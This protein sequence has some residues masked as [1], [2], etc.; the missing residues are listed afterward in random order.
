MTPSSRPARVLA[1]LRVSTE[2]QARSGAGIE[3]Q[4]VSIEEEASRRSWQV[5]WVIDDGYGAGDLRRPGIPE[6]LG[7]L[8]RGEADALVAAKLDRLSRSVLD[9]ANLLQRSEKEHWG[10]VLLDLDLDT[11]KPSGRLVAH[12][13]ASVAEFERQRIGERTK[14]ALAAVRARG[15]RLGRPPSVPESV[16]EWVRAEREQGQTFKAIADLLTADG[17]PTAQGGVRWW[18]S[19]VRAVAQ[20][21][22]R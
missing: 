1:Y 18:P 11:T 9:F 15:V 8:A 12:V 17:V 3:A 6:A 2:E 20:S 10:L 7:R 22:I 14:E 5:E 4:R 13:M 16:R 21:A 19:T